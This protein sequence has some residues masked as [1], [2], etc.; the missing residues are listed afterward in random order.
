MTVLAR[1]RE[2]GVVRKGNRSD[3]VLV[4]AILFL[5]ALGLLMIYSATRSTGTFSMERQMIFVAA[6]LIVYAVF[7]N[8]DYREYRGIIP[9]IAAVIMILLLVVFLFEPVSDSGVGRAQRWIPLGFFNLQPSEFAKVAV[10]L[11]LAGLLAPSNRDEVPQRSPT[12]K[13]V[14]LA[15]LVVAVPATLIYRQPDLGTSLV[16]VFILLVLLFAAGATWRQMLTLIGVGVIGVVIVLR[17]GLLSDYQ[18]DRLMCLVDPA[19]DPQDLC[20]QLAQSKRAI[21]SGQLFGKGLFQEDT[22]THFEYVPEQQTDF[23]FTAVG[24]QFGLLGGLV[25]LTVFA[26]IVWRLLVIGANSRDRFGALIAVGTAAMIMFHVFVNIGMT[27]GIMPVTGLPLPFLSQGGS[28]YIA[29]ALALGIANSVWLL[30][31]PVPS[32]NQLL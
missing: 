3:R 30:R 27:V 28:F 4:C 8:I 16:F 12:W 24:E 2:V 22:L 26:V 10:I 32:E 13:K 9:M 1:L 31:T 17:F 25:V 21:G 20:Y 23:I 11:A 7:T 14:G 18:T 29:M 5:S 6:G 19:V 15:V